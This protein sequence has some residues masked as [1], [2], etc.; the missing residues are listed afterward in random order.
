MARQSFIAIQ[1]KR[2][3]AA[4]REKKILATRSSVV[5]SLKK[6]LAG[7]KRM[8]VIQAVGAEQRVRGLQA[9]ASERAA[10]AAAAKKD[11]LELKKKIN[12][13]LGGII[14]RGLQFE[15]LVEHRSSAAPPPV[16]Y[17]PYTL[18]A[19]Q[20]AFVANFIAEVRDNGPQELRASQDALD[21]FWSPHEQMVGDWDPDVPSWIDGVSP[22]VP[23]PPHPPKRIT[24]TP[25][26]NPWRKIKPEPVDDKWGPKSAEEPNL[27]VLHPDMTPPRLLATVRKE[28]PH[29]TMRVPRGSVSDTDTESESEYDYDVEIVID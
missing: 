14:L 7:V 21:A 25:L 26:A 9:A 19:T 4:K 15:R 2:V 23:A 6:N 3:L 28:G 24:P 29:P 13:V 8:S 22:A 10:A 20:E 1:R 17:R 27:W 16:G 12:T 18:N 5:D 11:F